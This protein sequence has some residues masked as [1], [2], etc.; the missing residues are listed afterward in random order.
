MGDRVVLKGAQDVYQSIHLAQVAD[1]GGLLER[2]LADGA[3]VHVFNG[4]VRELLRVVQ[5]GESVEA[6][7][8]NFGDAD[9]SFARV[10]QRAEVGADGREQN[11][12][13]ATEHLRP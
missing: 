5:G 11:A 4:G 10:G 13:A 8:G 1:V 9:V 7:V 2:V 12:T 6:I 3:H